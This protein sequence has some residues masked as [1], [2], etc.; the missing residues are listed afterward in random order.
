MYYGKIRKRCLGSTVKSS[1]HTPFLINV[2]STP[3]RDNRAREN[4]KRLDFVICCSKYVFIHLHPYLTKFHC[5]SD[6]LLF[7]SS[8]NV[9]NTLLLLTG[10]I[11]ILNFIL[12]PIATRFPAII[13]KI[14][15]QVSRPEGIVG[16]TRGAE[17]F[18]QKTSKNNIIGKM[19]H[20][21]HAI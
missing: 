13:L 17:L 15:M 10:S 7:T 2:H 14:Q 3:K 19:F 18:Q 16:N 6:T 8:N 11:D 12:A 20:I 1:C 21:V 9:L 4:R 5:F